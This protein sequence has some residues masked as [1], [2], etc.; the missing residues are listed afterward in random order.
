MIMYFESS[1]EST[2]ESKHVRGRMAT[3]LRE[4][5]RLSISVARAV[6]LRR[7][8]VQGNATAVQAGTTGSSVTTH[9]SQWVTAG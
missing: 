8:V 5:D 6:P 9:F 1:F 2:I 4:D 7:V 3:S